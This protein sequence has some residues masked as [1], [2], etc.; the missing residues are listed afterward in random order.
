MLYAGYSIKKSIDT[1][2]NY[3]K[4]I[5]QKTEIIKMQTRLDS[6][7]SSMLKFT[8][9]LLNII[10]Y[11]DCIDRG[12][13]IY[14]KDSILKG[15]REL[16]DIKDFN[17]TIRI[18]NYYLDFQ[19][20]GLQNIDLYDAKPVVRYLSDNSYNA[21]EELSLNDCVITE[22]KHFEIYFAEL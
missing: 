20:I 10:Q 15:M 19:S 12:Q 7:L 22:F 2:M 5:N 11:D 17:D 18:I 4:M 13:L 14:L 8:D 6:E 9:E 1:L 16:S 3:K 21:V